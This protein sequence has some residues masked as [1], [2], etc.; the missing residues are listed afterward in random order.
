[1]AG[2]DYMLRAVRVYLAEIESMWRAA[3]EVRR[4]RL[5]VP[6]CAWIMWFRK[7]PNTPIAKGTMENETSFARIVEVGREL[8]GIPATSQQNL[9]ETSGTR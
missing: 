7:G 3:D 1:M 9:L 2:K 4:L 6:S 8:F 5:L